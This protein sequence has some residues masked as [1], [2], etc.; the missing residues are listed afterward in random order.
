M[1]DWRDNNDD[2]DLFLTAEEDDNSNDNFADDF[3]QGGNT[4]PDYLFK[5]DVDDDGVEDVTD[6]DSDNDGLRN[7][8]EFAGATYLNGSLPFDDDDTDGV[9]NYLDS[10]AT[11]YTDSN[12]DGVDDRVDRDRDGIPNFFDLD[13]DNDGTLD[14]VENGLVD[15][16]DDGTLSEG[17]SITDINGNGLDDA[18]DG[19]SYG[20]AT[21]VIDESAVASEG[22]AIGSDDGLW[23]LFNAASDYLI[24]DLGTNGF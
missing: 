2:N 4:V 17:G 12:G 3:T 15:G 6:L 21:A 19:S 1:P 14:L 10:D 22:N 18:Y 9:F 20:F 24:L 5:N 23:A 16:D 7:T 13:S 8:E 11:N